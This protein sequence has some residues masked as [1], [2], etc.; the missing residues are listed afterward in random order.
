MTETTKTDM[1]NTAIMLDN[2]VTKR[3]GD[4]LFK[5][6]NGYEDCQQVSVT[7]VAG[8]GESEL[9]LMQT[10][11]FLRVAIMEELDTDLKTLIR[12]EILDAF[13]TNSG[14]IIQ[15]GESLEMKY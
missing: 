15:R 10:S 9:D 11:N 14:R 6:I 1:A 8:T 13:S 4:A 2:E 3:V 5:L 12:Q 7:Q